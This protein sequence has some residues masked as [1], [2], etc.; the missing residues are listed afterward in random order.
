MVSEGLANYNNCALPN[1]QQMFPFR[2]SMSFISAKKKWTSCQSHLNVSYPCSFNTRSLE[3][4]NL[5]GDHPRIWSTVK[6]YSKKKTLDKLPCS[7]PL[8]MK[9]LVNETMAQRIHKNISS[10][11]I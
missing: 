5:E 3:P 8:S 10:I 2:K 6:A 11:R 4:E 7:T 1:L 9:N